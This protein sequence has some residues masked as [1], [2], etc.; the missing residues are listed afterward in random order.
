MSLNLSV[1]ETIGA[2]PLVA[3]D[4]L[5]RGLDGRIFAKL[6]FFNPGL[7][8]KDRIAKRIIEDALREGVLEP[9]QTVVELTSG[10]TG[11]GVAIVCAVLGHDFV[12]VMSA[13]NSPERAQMMRAYGAE[14][15]IV[16]Q[17][18]G[19]RMGQVSGDDLALV[20]ARAQEITR[21]RNAFRIDQFHRA[22]SRTAHE[23]GTGAE[24]WEQSGGAV[25]AFCDFVGSG[26][27]FA[28][29]SSALK[30]R[31]PAVR[32]Y[33]VEPA[34]A[35]IL[36]GRPVLRPQHRIQGGGYAMAELPLLRGVAADGYVSIDDGEARVT[37]Q[38]LARE[39]GIL[40]G[41]SAGANLAAALRLLQGPERGGVIAILICDTGLKYMSTDLFIDT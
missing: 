15:V 35:E 7:S 9:G 31:K 39:E 28:G 27:A 12:A 33:V 22:G 6:E 14:V 41:Y 26:G 5:T 18:A 10:S 17:A 40:G 16:P 8:K 32:A 1:V 20:E 25:T 30:S 29:V 38:R 21:A 23:D 3:L 37:A 36:A 4:R 19:A 24:I 11:V 2:T 13:G 34:G